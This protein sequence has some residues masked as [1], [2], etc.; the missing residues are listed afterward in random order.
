VTEDL[1]LKTFETLKSSAN[2][3]VFVIHDKQNDLI[4][5]TATL[6]VESKFTHTC[7]KVC[8]GLTRINWFFFFCN[9]QNCQKVGHI[10]DVVTDE[11]CRGNGFGK[12]YIICFECFC[13]VVETHTTQVD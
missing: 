6:L 9:C 11:S 1:F 8:D 7:G 5:G 12:M 10:E 2:C 13:I 3:F 4:V